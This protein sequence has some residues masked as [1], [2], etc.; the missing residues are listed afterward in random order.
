MARYFR[1]KTL[2]SKIESSYGVD[3]SPTELAN[4]VFIKNAVI[5]PLVGEYVERGQAQNYLGFTEQLI[6]G[7]SVGITGDVEVAGSGTAGVVPPWGPQLRAAGCSELA[8]AAAHN[9]TA[10]AG[11]STTIT[12]AAGASISDEAYRGMR[13]DLTGG[14]GSGQHRTISTY[15]GTSKIATVSQVFTTPPDITTAYSIGA[16]VAYLPVSTG[17][18][19]TYDYWKMDGKQHKLAGC[20]SSFEMKMDAKT[21]PVFALNKMGLY[22]APTDSANVAVVTTAYQ[23]PLA[24]NNTNTSGFS[25]HGYPGILYQLSLNLSNKL[26]HRNVVGQE[27]IQLSDRSPTGKIVIEDPTLAQKNYFTAVTGVT[28]DALDLTHGTVAGNIVRIHAPKVQLTNPDFVDKDGIIG[29]SLD[30]RF[31]PNLGNDE[32][33]IQ[34]D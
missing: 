15:N 4:A 31:L 22:V 7:Q 23:K 5:K 25:L 11:S 24:V 20:R 1:I 19:S 14:V 2:L 28:L 27:D 30:M 18:E 8:L 13:I 6:V 29:L 9:G 12:L 21:I 17:Q 16:Q 10:A 32:I 3:P 34:V 33:A 26:A